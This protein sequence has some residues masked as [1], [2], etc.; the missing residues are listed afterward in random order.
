MALGDF[1]LSDDR[2]APSPLRKVN[3][4]LLQ[5]LITQESTHRALRRYQTK[6]KEVS[7]QW[8]RE[9]YSNRMHY[10]DG[11]LAFARAD[12]FLEELLL[13]PPLLQT[14]EDGQT[15]NLVDPL[16]IAEDIL[17]LRTE[18]ALDFADSMRNVPHDHLD[19]RKVL[20]SLQMKKNGEAT[21]PLLCRRPMNPKYPQKKQISGR[22]VILNEHLFAFIFITI[23]IVTIIYFLSNI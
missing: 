6:D 17:E 22:V 1:G 14:A 15:A 21:V 11:N 10:F 16:R 19:I 2:R 7:F 20:L 5:T 8:L 12:D 9:F 23:Q 18:V 4:D 13:A 3:F